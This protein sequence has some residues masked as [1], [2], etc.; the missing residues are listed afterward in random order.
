MLVLRKITNEKK[1]V[2]RKRRNSG[3]IHRRETWEI[4]NWVYKQHNEKK[5]GKQVLK[6][7]RNM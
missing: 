4:H 2:R 5:K 7:A 6:K 1:L 3:K